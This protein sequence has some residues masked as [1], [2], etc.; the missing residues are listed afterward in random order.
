MVKS[1]GVVPKF[2]PEIVRICFKIGETEFLSKPVSVGVELLEY[3]KRFPV[4]SLN[5]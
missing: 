4:E 5:V 2:V 3:E 1:S